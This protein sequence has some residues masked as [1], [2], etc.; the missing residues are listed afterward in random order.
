MIDF[1]FSCFCERGWIG[2]YCNIVDYCYS[3]FCSEY[4]RCKNK[5]DLYNCICDF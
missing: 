3:L 1:N 2:L 5:C 4:G